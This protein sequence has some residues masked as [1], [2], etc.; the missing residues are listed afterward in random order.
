[1]K[2]IT[3]TAAAIAAGALSLAGAGALSGAPS[4]PPPN[5]PGKACAAV[6]P[7]TN[8]GTR[9]AFQRNAGTPGHANQMT[10]FTT[11]CP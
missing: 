5:N 3:L 9:T 6:S 10:L 7:T 1:M 2:R 11:A 8:Q 4:P